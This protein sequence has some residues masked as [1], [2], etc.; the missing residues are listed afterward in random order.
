MIVLDTSG[1]LAALLPSQREHPRARDLLRAEAPPLA[2][3]P[4]VLAEIDYFLARWAGIEFEL[5]LLE[6]VAGGAYELVRFDSAD[7]AAAR[8]L[9]DRY[10]ALNIG[11]ADASVV[12]LAEKLGTT[13]VLTLDERHFRTLQTPAG[14]S[15]T[16]LPAD[17]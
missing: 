17:A 2:L 7:V 1:L 11:L 6:D 13:R 4:F 5:A 12:V 9:I 3:S 16:L 8:G 15:L 14:D 10:R